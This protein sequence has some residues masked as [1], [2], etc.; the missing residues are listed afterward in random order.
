MIKR[1]YTSCGLQALRF[2]RWSRKRYAAFASR[3]RACTMGTLRCHIV[4]RLQRKNGMPVVD[5]PVCG[6]LYETADALAEDTGG[7]PAD[8]L[9]AGMAFFVTACCGVAAD[10]AAPCAAL[11]IYNEVFPAGGSGYVSGISRWVFLKGAVLLRKNFGRKLVFWAKASLFPL[12]PVLAVATAG[13]IG[14]NA[15]PLWLNKKRNFCHILWF[16]GFYIKQ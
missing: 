12:L 3:Q 15:S 13:L 6:C 2:R 8:W 5:T 7:V 11:S 14:R 1:R 10:A 16:M 9:P 4:E